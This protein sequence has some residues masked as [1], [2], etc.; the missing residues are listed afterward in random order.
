MSEKEKETVAF[1]FRTIKSFDDACKKV[2][3]NPESLPL[4]EELAEEFRKPILASYKLMVIFKAINDGWTPD[5]SD[6]D[7]RKYFPWFEVS[8]S[9]SDFSG[10]F[11]G[12]IC[13][14]TI[15]GSRL[16]TDSSEKAL[17]MA[18]Q[19]QDLYVQYSLK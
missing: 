17:Y 10:S 6:D 16:L 19:F 5:W 14:I 8:P 9:G 18:N 13:A 1:D 4:L 11:C 2:G 3:I 7:Q 15:V 12:Y